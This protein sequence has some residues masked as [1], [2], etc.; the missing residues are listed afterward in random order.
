MN[1]DRKI[2]LLKEIT[3]KNGAT[4]NEEAIAKQ[5]INDFLDQM[6]PP[7]EKTLDEI[8]FLNKYHEIKT[9][10]AKKWGCK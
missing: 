2:K 4:P 3:V 6:Y 5:K 1:I 8:R 10:N 9:E 7:E